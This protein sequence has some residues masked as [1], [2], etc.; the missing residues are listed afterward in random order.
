MDGP[1]QTKVGAM[2]ER[3]L[4]VDLLAAASDLAAKDQLNVLMLACGLAFARLLKEGGIADRGRRMRAIRA[5]VEDF[6]N[7]LRKYWGEQQ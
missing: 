3:L 5:A 7:I 6:S 4:A 1:T 2:R